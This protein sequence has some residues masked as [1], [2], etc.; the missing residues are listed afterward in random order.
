M[1]LL[2]LLGA[3][4][5]LLVLPLR[6]WGRTR[7]P[8]G[9]WLAVTV[10]GPVVDVVGRPRFFWQVR[11]QRTLS[12]HGLDELVSA[13]S[14]DE[15]V[16]GL[17]VTIRSMHA[18]M[19]SAASLRAVLA[20][21]RA[22]GK[23]VVVHLP[24]GGDTKE[25]FVASA[26]S[27]VL[28]CPSAQLSPLGFRSASRYLKTALDRA[29]IVPQVFACGEFKAAGE[30]LVRDAMSPAQRAQ[31]ERV[32]DGL[33]EAVVGAVAEGRR[34]SR[35]RAAAIVDEAPYFGRA[36]VE[37]GLADDLAYEDEVKSK[38][39]PGGG[40]GDPRKRTP[41]LDGGAWLARR[42]RPLV[43]RIFRRPAIVVVPI[44]GA[45][46]HATGVLGG[47]STGERV[48]RMIRAA[49]R[50]RCV[51]GVI[52]HIDSPGGSALASDLMHHEIEQLAREK[53]VVACM[54]NVAASGGYYV[55][56]P[57]RRIVA[58]PVTVT[59]SIGV[60]AARLDVD[61]LLARLGIT[62]EVVQRGARAALLSPLGPLDADGRA[63]V[64][65][66]LGATYRAFLAVVAKGRS[67]PEEEVE[68]LARG[69]VYTGRDAH[70]VGLVDALGG[71]DVALAEV[72]ALVDARVRDRLDVLV[73]RTPL[74]Q[75][76]PPQPPKKEDAA[77]EAGLALL[78]SLLPARERTV[79]ELA[80]AGERVLA[81]SPITE[82]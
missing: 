38:L 82:T 10:D 71:F 31:V 14:K 63:T 77:R 12:I 24:T 9:A 62:T 4:V 75:I 28:L 69:R 44:H 53:P 55:A 39:D 7:T 48:T 22:S 61:P 27:R 60:V 33:H 80:R 56:A 19:G 36:A 65:R 70:E 30:T 57:A 72:K 2:R 35:E 54:A 25:V 43:R 74:G 42:R 13:M 6:L 5:D 58:Q 26:A 8:R 66:E 29:A 78:T 67:L 17:L 18:G 47:L 32:I 41:I 3:L 73:A 46:T 34:V 1:I 76:P 16:R 23:D 37:A 68:R 51:R 64:E 45:I 11:R 20:R 50:D 21:A 49:R 79:L 81:M 52:L 59:G 15:R 40:A